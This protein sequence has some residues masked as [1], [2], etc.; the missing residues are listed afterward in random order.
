MDD[1]DVDR[2]GLDR[3]STPSLIGD[4][5]KQASALLSAEIQLMRLEAT[6]KVVTVLVA[7]VSLVAAAVFIIVALIFLLQGLVELL[8][9]FHW[10]PFAASFAVGGGIAVVALIAMFVAIRRL[11]AARLRPARA[12]R[13]V[14]DTSDMVK[15]LAS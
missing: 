9:H 3:P 1:V 12:I 5:I 10:A 4:A 13:Q 15:G 11:S 14:R 6:E 7:I 2:G 8:V